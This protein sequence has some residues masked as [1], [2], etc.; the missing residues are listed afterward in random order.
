MSKNKGIRTSIV[1]IVYGL[2]IV[3][4]IGAMILKELT[5]EEVKNTIAVTSPVAILMIGWFAKDSNQSHTMQ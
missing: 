1:A 5:F 2:V 3:A 4:L